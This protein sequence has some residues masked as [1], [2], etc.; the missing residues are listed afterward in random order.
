MRR[1]TP[2]T[3]KVHGLLDYATG[4]QL[5]L[6]GD[7][8]LKIAGAVHAGYSVVTD[9]ELGIVKVLPYRAHLALDALWTV[10]VA[11]SP[12]VT[13]QYRKGTH[14]WLPHVLIA[15]WEATSLLMSETEARS[16]APERARAA[17]EYDSSARITH[18]SAFD[19]AP[20]QA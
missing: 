11:A 7:K 18:G 14:R 6:L 4:A 20:S 2:I 9:Y 16:R 10:G 8:P 15:A 3:S 1:P 5:Q 13:G 19:A 17:N 12:F